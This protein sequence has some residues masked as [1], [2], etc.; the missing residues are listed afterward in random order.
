MSPRAVRI[1]ETARVA[2]FPYGEGDAASAAHVVSG[3]RPRPVQ[4][5][6]ASGSLHGGL[7]AHAPGAT[8]PHDPPPAPDGGHDDVGAQAAFAQ[9]YSQGERAGIEVA[10]RQL[11][12]VHQ[13]LGQTLDQLQ[14]LREE[15]TYRTERQ[16]VE[17]ALAMAARILHREVSLDRE[18]LLVMARIALDRMGDVRAATIK[19]HPDDEAAARG[20][21]ESWPGGSVVVVADASIRPGGCVVQTDQGQIEIGVDAQVRELATALL[22]DLALP[23]PV[24]A[25]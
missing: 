2:R 18:L 6:A 23:S 11:Q 14:T 12:A 22:G 8:Y 21:R 20:A 7:T 5:V 3:A 15:L 10:A 9:G 16:V 25:K 1:A 4:V 13:R 19:L 24:A 17:L